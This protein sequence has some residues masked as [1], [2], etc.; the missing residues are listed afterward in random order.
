MSTGW[1][2]EYQIVEKKIFII[3]ADWLLSALG[4]TN[5]D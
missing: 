4:E 2:V 1:S 5:N 3:D